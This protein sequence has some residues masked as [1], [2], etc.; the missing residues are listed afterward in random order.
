MKNLNSLNMNDKVLIV[1]DQFIE[2]ND[3]RLM[4]EKA[5][6]KVCGIARSVPQALELIE[7]ERPGLVLL[8]I[9]L[10]GKQTGIDLA[11]Q[12]REE[13]VAFV[14]LSANSSQDVLAAAKAT[15]PYGFLV[16]PFR[17]KD[18]L[19]TLEIARYRHENSLES[20]LRRESALHKKLDI[21]RESPVNRDQKL[22]QC[23]MALQ[24]F[25]PFD[26][27]SAVMQLQDGTVVHGQDFLR[28][29]FD[30]YQH[31]G[32]RELA[33]ISGMKEPALNLL[34]NSMERISKPAFYNDESFRQLTKP[35]GLHKLVA[36][37]FRMGSHM[38]YPIPFGS[39]DH[40]YFH[41]YSRRPD[42]YNPAHIALFGRMAPAFTKIT[43]HLAQFGAME[44]AVAAPFRPSAHGSGFEGIVGSSHL[45]LNVFD[46]IAQVAPLDT[47]I[48]I[49]GESGTG[50]ERIADCIHRLSPRKHKPLVKV[51]CAALPATLIES[52]LFGH[53]R[54]AFTGALDKRIG[55]F[56]QAHEGTIFLDEIGEMPMELQAKL[57]RVL[58]EK[59]V[60]RIGSRAP[61][62]VNIR[63]IA[64][65]NRNLEKEVAEGRFRLDLYYRLNVFPITIPPLRERKEDIPALVSHFLQYFNR[66]TGKRITGLSDKALRSM[67]EYNWPG[68]IREL[69][70]LVERSILLTRSNIIE[71]VPIPSL[72]RKGSAEPAGEERIKTIHENERDHILTVLKKCNGRIWGMG[73]AAEL[74]NVPPTTLNS[75]MK[76][77]GIRKEHIS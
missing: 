37:S 33:A 41:F 77:L 21:I 61:I 18:L 52:E 15:Q 19:I 54:G 75:K 71:E 57:L 53:E 9:F 74:L 23:A 11:K 76:K 60:E 24:A 26:Y 56:E 40:F 31:I 63:I 25:I 58:Q 50:K 22:L 16:K 13:H 34:H 73:G 39:G 17:E 62:R 30:E 66:K 14:Y 48:L 10:K 44:T 46:N 65:T 68:N 64:A 3:L 35:A 42:A 32:P 28:T 67:M 69:E 12:L 2:A 45:L 7:K 1:E 8:D 29:G 4:L 47:S 51:N 36:D 72:Q 27:F 6:Y 20:S 70:H 59:E 5:G 38:V 43:E 49:L 55:K